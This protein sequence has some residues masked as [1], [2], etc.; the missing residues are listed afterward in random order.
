MTDT[1]PA[2][3]TP[4]PAALTVAVVMASLELAATSVVP[5]AFRM[6]GLARVASATKAWVVLSMTPT[7]RAPLTPTIPPAPLTL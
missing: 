2:T 6:V 1:A 7:D 5:P 3:P 4:P